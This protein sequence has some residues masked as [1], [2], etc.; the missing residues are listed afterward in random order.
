MSRERRLRAAG[1][2]YWF[3]VYQ[4]AAWLEIAP[5]QFPYAGYDVGRRTR[6]LLAAG[7]TGLSRFGRTVGKGRFYLAVKRKPFFSIQKCA[8]LDF[9]VAAS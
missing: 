3:G 7:A 9:S 6:P 4:G 8:N 5:Q 1:D 2:T